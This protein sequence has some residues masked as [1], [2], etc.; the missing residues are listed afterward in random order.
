MYIP[1]KTPRDRARI[2]NCY[3][4]LKGSL[5]WVVGSIPTDMRPGSPSTLVSEFTI[6][7]S[8][9]MENIYIRVFLKI[10]SGTKVI[11]KYGV[12]KMSSYK[13]C[14]IEFLPMMA[15]IDHYSLKMNFSSLSNW[16]NVSASCCA[17]WN[18]SYLKSVYKS[19][20]TK[21]MYFVFY[22]ISTT[23]ITFSF[24]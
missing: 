16:W 4:W 2:V 7:T 6:P 10:L 11:S 14:N 18:S 15:A 1:N 19:Q 23:K 13:T 24:I 22:T 20:S 5:V 9:Q 8:I 21:K 17:L 3:H 12:I